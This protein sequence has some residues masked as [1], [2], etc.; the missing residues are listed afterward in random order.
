[1]FALAGSPATVLAARLADRTAKG[2]RGAPRDAMIADETPPEIRGAAFGLRQSLDTVGA[3]VAPLA[4]IGL[5]LL[6]AQDIR[7]V[8]WVAVIPAVASVALAWVALKEPQRHSSATKPQPTLAGFRVIGA[9]TRRL[10]QLGF[11]F[12][13]ARFSESFLILKGVEAG[14][15]ITIAPLV[16]VLF[17]LAYLLGSYPAG[18][19]SDR[20]DP[21]GVLLAGIG[22]LVAA[23]LILSR[24][25]GLAGLAAGVALWGVHM[26]L[27]QGL[28]AR[29]IA[30]SSPPELRATSFGAFHFVTGIA[31]LLASVAAGMLWDREGSD[32]AFVAGAGV[33][34]VA[35]AM[36]VLLPADSTQ[37]QTRSS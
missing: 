20:R 6:F 33:A 3:F 26:A 2:I 34:A 22:V 7:L 23:D 16:L 14:L 37:H 18:A 21:K 5:M 13:L 12:T 8:F 11:L 10:I 25:W 19:L 30:D 24:D 28:F 9:P 31:T 29:M 35:G 4:A 27:T 36:L 1:L 15:S 17:N 32:A